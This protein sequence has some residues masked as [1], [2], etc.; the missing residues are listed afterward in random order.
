MRHQSEHIQLYEQLLHVTDQLLQWANTAVW[1]DEVYEQ[2]KQ[3]QQQFDQIKGK[4][5]DLEESLVGKGK[6][7]SELPYADQLLALAEKTN[8]LQQQTA[9]VLEDR[10][11]MIRK[12]KKGMKDMKRLNHAYGRTNQT[13]IAY[14]FDE[15][16]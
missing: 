2:G 1:E 3:L 7:L 15:K 13:P 5:M 4:I 10:M 8:K 11:A 6:P 14:F 16:K 12:S 9:R